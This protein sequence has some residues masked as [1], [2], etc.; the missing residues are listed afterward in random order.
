MIN[1]DYIS[2]FLTVLAVGTVYILTKQNDRGDAAAPVSEAAV[3]KESVT[4]D[5]NDDPEKNLDSSI[6]RSDS[7]SS[8]AS[9]SSIDRGDSIRSF[10]FRD[11][12]DED[13]VDS[14]TLPEQ[15]GL[16]KGALEDGQK[17]L[18]PEDA[19][20]KLKSR[21]QGNIVDNFLRSKGVM[22]TSIEISEGKE[23]EDKI[24]QEIV[25]INDKIKV[26]KTDY[27][28]G[29][30][31]RCQMYASQWP[32]SRTPR[33]VIFEDLKLLAKYGPHSKEYI[34]GKI[35]LLAKSFAQRGGDEAKLGSVDTAI[36]N[37]RTKVE[38]LT[39]DEMKSLNTQ[40][41]KYLN[42]KIGFRTPREAAI[43]SLTESLGSRPVIN[44]DGESPHKGPGGV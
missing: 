31:K 40:I 6:P 41:D 24:N 13:L 7:V 27:A 11:A 8:I 23:T 25:D 38:A 18:K 34:I 32:G 30:V 36:T 2:V 1:S 21:L 37:L 33:G 12:E 19:F 20:E 4:G 42:E 3:A 22:K 9:V 14:D 29:F 10:I 44:A 39:Q 5:G 26:M 28:D 35:D 43:N 17:T 16:K 15:K